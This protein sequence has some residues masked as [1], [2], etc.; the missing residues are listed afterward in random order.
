MRLTTL[1]LAALS[2]L[3][4]L[5]SFAVLFVLPGTAIGIA[6]VASEAWLLLGLLIFGVASASGVLLSLWQPGRPVWRRTAVALTA[7]VVALSVLDLFRNG[8]RSSA[9]S[10]SVPWLNILVIA[11]AVF[12]WVSLRR[13]AGRPPSRA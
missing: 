2:G 1:C 5:G 10:T 6:A 9:H 12:Y 13:A 8:T 7:I 4:C 11:V 3:I